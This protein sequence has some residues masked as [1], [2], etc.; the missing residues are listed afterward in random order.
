MI[1]LI[2]DTNS[3]III[4]SLSQN[5]CIIFILGNKKT[6]LPVLRNDAVIYENVTGIGRF[7]DLKFGTL[8]LVNLEIVETHFSLGIRREGLLI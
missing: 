7:E 1:S 4:V 6:I 5:R 2:I 3:Y 8:F